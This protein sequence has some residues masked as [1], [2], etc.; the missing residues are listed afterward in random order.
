MQ[1]RDTKG[2]VNLTFRVNKSD[3][4]LADGD[5]REELN[6]LISRLHQVEN[7]PNAR[8]KSFS[9]TGTAS[10]EGNYERNKQL[11]QK[12]MAS[13]MS[14][15]VKE[16]N[17][18]TRRQIDM[19]TTASVETWDRVVYLLRADNKI[20]ESDAIQEIID[21]YPDNPNRQSR[22]VVSLPFY[23]SL[24]TS[25]YLPRL[26]RVSYE[27]LFSQYRYLTGRRSRSALS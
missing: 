24:I 11:A 8:L 15:I 23:R 10:P 4:N 9:I 26:R 25:R 1:L 6:R 16:L 20:R 12:R 13:A 7:D 3:L 22:N 19:H 27:L 21:K 18:S 14:L 17:E 5:N 2:D